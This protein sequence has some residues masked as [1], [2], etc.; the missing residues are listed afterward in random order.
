MSKGRRRFAI[1][2]G[3]TAVALIPLV[4]YA[5]PDGSNSTASLPLDCAI[6]VQTD[7]SVTGECPDVTATDEVTTS[8]TT[9][10]AQTTAAPTTA[11]TTTVAPTTTAAPTT[12]IAPTTTVDSGAGA[13]FSATFA[14]P[15]EFQNEFTHG[16]SGELHSG[17][18]FG[19]DR[20][21]WHGDHDMNCGNPNTTHRDVAL[22]GNNNAMGQNDPAAAE[23]A[24]YACL[25]N[26]NPSAGHLMTS[27]NT[28]GYIIAWF[29]PD[30]VFNDVKKVCHDNN[31]TFLGNGLWWQ[32][33]FLTPAEY[34]H[35]VNVNGQNITG[36]LGYTSP[37]FPHGGPSTHQGPAANGI[38]FKVGGNSVSD[39]TFSAH[40]WNGTRSAN[41]TVNASFRPTFHVGG[42][43]TA[44]KAP[45]YTICVT[46]NGNDTLTIS[47]E[48]PDGT[49]HTSTVV[50]H[51]PQGDIKVVF[52]HDE[53]NPDKHRA[54][55][56]IANNTGE[57]YTYHWDN[58]EVFTD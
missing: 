54:A 28:E 20:S 32:I 3:I 53:Y 58:I 12:T 16:W 35:I 56:A 55:G 24:F 52:E 29:S 23:P 1:I 36:D 43:A 14:N 37:E 13:A 38:K 25:P 34:N 47:N 51:I 41:G 39:A 57:G 42:P 33:A 18:L 21:P 8:T 5:A 40:A 26:N 46:D 17:S 2:G 10:V 50:G 48:S 45:R 9:T 27:A 49:T 31:F 7:G 11:A 4:A 6:T 22:G 44:D 19:A 15:A 30:Q